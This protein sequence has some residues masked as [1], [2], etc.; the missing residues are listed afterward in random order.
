MVVLSV[1]TRSAPAADRVDPLVLPSL[2]FIVKTIT[3]HRTAI[4]ITII[5]IDFFVDQAIV[6][7][8]MIL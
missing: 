3:T 1:S 6:F 5:A 7:E 2:E 4:V 8:R